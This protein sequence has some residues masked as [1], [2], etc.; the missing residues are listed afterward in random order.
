M[1][2]VQ[3]ADFLGEGV[4]AAPAKPYD[5]ND[6][7]NPANPGGVS[8]NQLA[9]NQQTIQAGAARGS[10]LSAA[11]NASLVNSGQKQ[12]TAPPLQQGQFGGARRPAGTTLTA[13]APNDNLADLGRFATAGAR[14]LTNP[15]NAVVGDYLPEPVQAAVGGPGY[16]VGAAADEAA[17]QLIP[18]GSGVRG[19]NLIPGQA[20]TGGDQFYPSETL[21]SGTYSDGYRGTG[22]PRAL[23]NGASVAPSANAG[24][25]GTEPP[26]PG[27]TGPATAGDYGLGPIDTMPR[28]SSYRSDPVMGDIRALLAENSSQG[29]SEGEALLRMSSDRATANALGI[30]AG[31][32]GGAGARERAQRQALSTNAALGAQTS[33]QVA[34][35]RAQEENTRRA[36]QADLVGLLG[37]VAGQG[38]ARDLGYYS[39]D[40]GRAGSRDI[41]LANLT[42]SERQAQAD[43][44]ARAFEAE[45]NR[46]FQGNENEQERLLREAVFNAQQ[47]PGF[48]DDPVSAL[49]QALTGRP[50]H[51]ARV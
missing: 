47:Q 14:T 42:S 17:D 21:Q 51:T 29:P 45:Q 16:F 32:R 3:Y 9:K 33:Q 1:A 22:N 5:P 4:N 44:E 46:S 20:G 25:I 19:A 7:P 8:N 18:G 50:L 38:D 37:N 2:G 35:L 28:P 30:A 40:Q 6:E 43:R 48:A 26:A 36:R 31:A 11:S 23:P 34:A 41:A 10:A 49:F 13:N 15:I 39:A 24:G 27:V 12:Y